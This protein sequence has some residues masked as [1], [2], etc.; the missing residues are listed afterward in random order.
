[1]QYVIPIYN[2]LINADT[3]IIDYAMVNM[4]FAKGLR[5]WNRVGMW[6]RREIRVGLSFYV[7]VAFMSVRCRCADV[8]VNAVLVR[9]QFQAGGVGRR[10]LSCAERRLVPSACDE[11]G[12]GDVDGF[13]PGDVEEVEGRAVELDRHGR[14]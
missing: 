6:L 13:L 9:D 14:D 11:V 2:W 7:A 3:T 4:T 8:F 10:G 12:K 5:V 1:M